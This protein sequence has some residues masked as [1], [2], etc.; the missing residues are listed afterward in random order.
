MWDFSLGLPPAGSK[1]AASPEGFQCVTKSATSAASP[2]TKTSRKNIEKLRMFALSYWDLFRNIRMLNLMMSC[3][4]VLM[5]GAVL[6]VL[7][8]MART[9]DNVTAVPFCV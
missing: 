3:C 8:V 2:A 4:V 6:Q 1:T 7:D 5:A 9:P